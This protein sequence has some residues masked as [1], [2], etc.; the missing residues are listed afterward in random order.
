M[1]FTDPPQ[2]TR[3][4]RLINKSF[5]PRTIAA[6]EPKIEAIVSRLLDEAMR[7]DIFDFVAD[8]SFQLPSMVICELLGIPLD[9]Q[10]DLKRWSD[11]ISGFSASARVTLEQATFAENVAIEAQTYLL[12]LFEQLRKNPGE[13]LLSKILMAPKEGDALTDAELSALAVQLFFAGFETTEGLLGNMLLALVNH[14][15]QLAML[16]Q[17]PELMDA[18]VEEALRYDSSIQKQS[19]VASENLVIRGQEVAKGDY[20]HFMIGAANRDPERF[21]NPDVFDIARTDPGNV[22]FGHGIHFC[23][24]APLARLEARIAMRQL[25]ERMPNLRV[26]DPQPQFAQL[27]A[28][29]KPLA[30]WVT[31]K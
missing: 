18:A 19:R 9:R 21:T 1:V 7:K 3:L 11:G 22:S 23:I 31:N 8:F 14:P 13:N 5:T 30:L 26:V 15:E 16:R 6:F 27:F 2:H 17:R 10:W 24:G 12:G 29:R 4:R 20:V 28:F 25:L